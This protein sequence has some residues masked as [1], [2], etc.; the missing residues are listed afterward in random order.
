MESDAALIIKLGTLLKL[1]IALDHS[2][3]QPVQELQIN[4]NRINLNS[5]A[6]MY[7]QPILWS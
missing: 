2:E 7:P 5:Q 1:A 3:T 6:V 4:A